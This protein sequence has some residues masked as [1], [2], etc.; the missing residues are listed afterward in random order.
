MRLRRY[1]LSCAC[2]WLYALA[3][4]VSRAPAP[5][6]FVSWTTETGLPQ[7]TV[8]D[9]HQ[10]RDGYIWLTTFDG[11]VRFDGVRFTVFDKGSTPGISSNRFLRMFEDSRG[12]LWAGTEEGGLVRYHQG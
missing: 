7:N 6:R 4:A 3:V 9:I 5:S 2:A 10:T 1:V 12:D 11:L 8:Y